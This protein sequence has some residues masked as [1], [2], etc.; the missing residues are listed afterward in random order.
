M[1]SQKPTINEVDFCGQVAST[2]NIVVNQNPDIFPFR[3]ARIEGYGVG[4]GRRKRK[5]LR[6]FNQNGKLVLCGEVKLPGTPQGRSPYDAKLCQDAEAKANDAGIRYFFTW[7]V[8]YFV[9]WDRSLWDKPLLD[10]RVWQRQLARTLTGPEDVAR[11]DNLNFI[12]TH[13]LPDLLRDLADILSGRRRDWL[14]PDDIF[15]RSLESHL[16]WPVQLA[17][18]YILEQTDKSKTFDLRVQRWMADQDRTFIRTPHEEWVKATD[19]MAK[20]LAYVWANRLIFYKALR[21][22]FP[23]LPRLELRSS[24]KKPDEAMEVFNRF[25]QKAVERSGDYE[26][27]LMPDT[28]DWAAEL[29]FH[30]VNAIDAWRGLLHGVESVD[31]REV[32]SDVVGRIFQKLIG[33]EERHRYG[34]HFTG[35]DVVDL[36]NGFCIRKA[37][38]VV[39]D[40]ACGSGSFLVR[41]YYRKR[42]LDPTR[43]HID[44]ISELYGCDI[45]LYPAH[46]A[47][48][49][50]AAREINDKANY[51]RIARRNFFDITPS[52][53]F[54]QLPDA[55]G[56]HQSIGLPVLDALVGNPPY[57]RQEKVEKKD[58]ARFGQIACEVWPDLRL[59]G[60]SDLH[61]YF[62]PAAARL[63]KSDGHFGFLTSSSWLDVE[64][65]FAL[66]GWILRHF[67][68]I[69][70]MESAAEPWFE[71]ARVKTCITILQRCDDEAARMANRVRFVRLHRKIADIIGVPSGQDEGDRQA[72][73][74]ALRERIMGTDEDCQDQD[75]RIIIKAQKELWADGVQAGS[76]LGGLDV[77]EAAE[78]EEEQELVNGEKQI[79][80]ANG[81]THCCRIE[82]VSYCAGKWG[83]Y[84]RAPDI[85]FEIMRR[86][87]EQFVRLGEIATIRRGITSG[88]DAFFMPKDI[89]TEVIGKYENDR[90]FR[91]NAGGAPR[92]D[93]LSGKLKIIQAGDGSIHPIEAK[94]LA[95]EVHSLMKIDR[96]IVRTGDLDRVV[97]LVGD[98]MDQLKTKAPWTWRYIRHG[99]TATFPSKKSK[100]VPVPKRSTCAARDPWY[101]LTGL[102]RPGIAFWPM[103]QQYRHIIAGNP[104]K[105]ICNHNL[106]DIASDSLNAGEK[107]ALVAI[108][109][110][111]LVGLFKTFYGRFAGTEGNLKTEVVD[112]NLLEVPDPRGIS[113]VLAK[114]FADALGH[115]SK[116]EVSRLVEEQLMDCHS[117]DRARRMAAGPIVLSDELR[118]TDRRD[119]D[120]AVFE[121]LGV[122]DPREREKYI[123]RLYEATAWHFREIRVVEIQKMQ[124][125][126]KSNNRRFSAHDLAADIWD[127]AQLEDATPLGEWIGQLRESDS[128]VII[129]EE[130]PAALSED[131][132]FSPNTVYFGKS[133]KSYLECQSRGQAELVTR[134]GNLGIS[135]EVKLP[136]DLSP[137]LKLLERVNRRI[138]VV[139]ERFKEL[140]ESRTSDDRIRDQLAEVLERWFVLGR[141]TSKASADIEE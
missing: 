56:G 2:A 96:P 131:V 79:L 86:F 32:P 72:A 118:Q 99:M 75:M 48:L 38:D 13:F 67:R 27:L 105:L 70:I 134:L 129:P 16:D 125:R 49:N 26:P 117:P 119:L 31:F 7:N 35:D 58:K 77:A 89:T 59:S 18:S 101:D 36:I 39:L 15:I 40:P 110:S 108:L 136:A 52:K 81:Q 128:L 123:D 114:R 137:C 4:A 93:V 65:G 33:P 44:L 124:Q 97:L 60:R 30:P 120:H 28:K 74:D 8:N 24:V 111:T 29:I 127:A 84:V 122:S 62:W 12:K 132:M 133:R 45:A 109:N 115:M 11:E 6:F 64:Y 140:I 5:D 46:L 37:E 51:P 82:R 135:G 104:E 25:F 113:T 10:R 55:S 68:I 121:L 102:V 1:A 80:D 126:A 100:P 116:R 50:L 61:C 22:R 63:L 107:K 42:Q 94:Y 90:D 112:V 53:S 95:P 66:Q 106:F 14:P 41:A 87:G 130:H 91:R 17:S 85:Y 3:E 19:N 78:E 73:I 69:A 9:L 47:T 21:A 139:K 92:K 20:T 23:D 83:R 138:S 34:Q 103:A 76:I 88:C 54:C 141:E 71:D 98:P 57:V 43:Q